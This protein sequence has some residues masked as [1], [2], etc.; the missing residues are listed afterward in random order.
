MRNPSSTSISRSCSL[1]EVDVGKLLHLIHIYCFDHFFI[2]EQHPSFFAFVRNFLADK[3]D[4]V[5]VKI[6][7]EA[8]GVLEIRWHTQ[9]E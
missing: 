5:S 8:D 4:V 9:H 3:G 7:V 6:S 1:K 2:V